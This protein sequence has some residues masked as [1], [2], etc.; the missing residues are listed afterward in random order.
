MFI[1]GYGFGIFSHH[2]RFHIHLPYNDSK[3]L[4]V[5]VIGIQII[6]KLQKIFL[7]KN[8]KMFSLLLCYMNNI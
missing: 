3:S 1:S 8:H 2:T 4:S 5:P 7:Q 6:Y